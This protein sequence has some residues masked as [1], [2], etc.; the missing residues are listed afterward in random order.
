M[1]EVDCTYTFVASE[2]QINTLSVCRQKNAIPRGFSG[3]SRKQGTSN[4]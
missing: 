4:R 1:E 2:L 3:R